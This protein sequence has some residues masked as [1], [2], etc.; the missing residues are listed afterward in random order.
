MAVLYTDVTQ[1]LGTQDN[2]RAMTSLAM[3]ESLITDALV[4]AFREVPGSVRD[5]LVLEVAK[6]WFDRTQTMAGASQFADFSTGRP[7]M[8]P[9]DP[10]MT[11]WPV[12]HRY[13]TPF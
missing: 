2:A 7:V 5:A 4:S 12:I 13:V 10:L 6:S 3:A 1:A 9:R 11:V 8:A